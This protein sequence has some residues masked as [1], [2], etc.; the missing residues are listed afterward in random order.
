MGP[1]VPPLGFIGLG[2]MGGAVVDRLL[3]AGADVFVHDV[4][5]GKVRAFAEKGA[6]A[7]ASAGGVG[8]F[9]EIVFGCLPSGDA[10]LE[11]V[12][13]LPGNDE[14]GA[15]IYVELSTIG[16]PAIARIE[17]MLSSR[18]IALVDAPL[19]GGPRG[20]RAGTLSSMVAGDEAALERVR[21]VLDLI[22]NRVFYIGR[23][24]GQ[25]QLMKLVNNLISGANMAA[26]FEALV[27]GAKA[28]LDAQT[29]VDVIN[30]S[31]G[32][33][34]ATEDKIPASVLDGSFDYG[35][36]IAVLD[37][38]ISLG[39]E[40]AMA[41]GVPTLALSGVA[42]LWARAVEQG[43]AAADFTSLITYVEKPA[44]AVVRRKSDGRIG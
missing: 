28:G 17:R 4:D 21:P 41:L 6:K 39:L 8:G 15:G 22:G 44:G 34:S 26:A 31:T 40:E 18:G 16:R 38:D 1:G 30:A 33:N 5:V 14:K 36:T 13:Q 11:T 32:R 10:C 35:A 42:R 24:P 12:S 7:C 3:G 25:A 43:G 19:S 2:A 20:A 37:K 29:M 9:A 23:T 27:I